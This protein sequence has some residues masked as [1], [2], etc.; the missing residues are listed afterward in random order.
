MNK[1]TVIIILVLLTI[2]YMVFDN[3]IEEKP[4]AIPDIEQVTEFNVIKPPLI[5]N[6]NDEITESDS[7]MSINTPSNVNKQLD[8]S[9]KRSS[10][11]KLIDISLSRDKF[12]YVKLAELMEQMENNNEFPLHATEEMKR[13]KHNLKV[14][15][16][17]AKLSNELFHGEVQDYKDSAKNIA[18]IM[19]LQKKLIVSTNIKEK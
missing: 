13:L 8:H 15:Q 3:F 5:N 11:Q 10:R 16:E 7:K 9:E 19:E 12:R 1:M 14:S 17:I 18:L 2:G 6:K 4:I